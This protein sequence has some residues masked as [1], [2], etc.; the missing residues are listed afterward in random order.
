MKKRTH[1]LSAVVLGVAFGVALEY[2]SA[3]TAIAFRIVE[4]TI[5][6]VLGAVLPDVDT[7]IGRHRKTLHNLPVIVGIALFPLV[8]GNLQ[9]VWMGVLLH[10]IEDMVGTTRGVA[11][12]YPLTGR[13]FRWPTV[14]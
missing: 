1:V 3:Y 13:E 4:V 5:P 2:N 6:I 12:L 10:L 11:W 9:Y 14:S 7:E 8:F